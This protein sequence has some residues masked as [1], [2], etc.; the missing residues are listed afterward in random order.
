[1]PQ[2]YQWMFYELMW[3][4]KAH[5][6]YPLPWWVQQYFRHWSDSYDGGL[7]DSKQAAF[8]SNANYR[9]WNM[10]GVKDHHQESLVGQA[11]E[12]EP[13]NDKYTVSFFLFDP[14][15]RTVKFP[16]FPEANGS[17]SPL[18]QELEDGYL[19]VVNTTWRS[20]L[21]VTVEAKALATTVGNRQRSVVL[22]QYRAR[23]TGAAPARLWLCV[24]VSAH[25]VTGLDRRFQNGD[26]SD[27]RV[28]F[29]KYLPAEQRLE[30]NSTWGPT[31]DTP[32]T[33]FGLYG[34]DADSFDP[35]TYINNSPYQDLVANGKLNGREMVADRIAGLCTGVFAWE[36]PQSSDFIV[37]LRLPV[38]DFRGAD[39]LAEL[40]S[41]APD[42]LE[43]NNRNFW[44]NKLDNTGLQAQLPPTVEHLFKLFRTCR[45]NILILADDGAI[46]PG[47]TIYDSFWIRD[48][49]VEGVACALS[50]EQ[51]LP[52]QQFSR[53]YPKAFNT[54]RDR[55]GPVSLYGFFGDEHEKND[56]EWDSNG[57]AL[58]A[59][60]RFDRIL[61]QQK[62]F[63]AGMFSPYIIDGARWIR[64]NRSAF[65][66]L[67]SGWSAE[68]LGDKDKPHYWDD[69]W[70]IAG[71]YEA[72][73]LAERI[74]A[75]SA[76][77][78]WSIYDDVVR[79]TRDSMRWVLGEQHRQG[80]WET[81]IPTGP[82]DAG[83]LDSTLIGMVA[84]FHPCR[85]YM[86]AKLGADIDFAARATLD[87]I[88][89]HFIDG[90]F[91]HDSAWN[92]YGPYLTLQLAH[93]FLL[94]GDV[95]RMDHCL[96]WVVG[97]AGYAK[98][99][100]SEG[101]TDQWQVV[102]GA[103]NEQ[104]CYPIAKN[105]AEFPGRWWYMGDIPHG[106]ACA[107]FILLLR[108]MLFF[109]A[110]ED[111]QPQI[112]LAPGILPQWLNEGETVG[113]SDAPTIF[114]TPFGYK[115]I[116]NSGAKTV[117]IEITQAPPD[118]VRLIYHCRFGT[119]QTAIANT[120]SLPIAGNEIVLPAGTRQ[121]T[122]TYR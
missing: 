58:W 38:D 6:N 34:N 51:E 86:G 66:L 111:G 121:A 52:T 100:R 119:V 80:N 10:I 32:P 19:P 67:H 46:H 33:A 79:A 61:G 107:E 104:H 85:L 37:N 88:W 75:A 17:Q 72:A 13:V 2:T 25:G 65:G 7:F 28:S 31:F 82:A 89:A 92:C 110:D 76:G 78:I 44:I 103:W 18:Q 15:A 101:S 112:Y 108:D 94:I 116:H 96:N 22:A 77:E 109:E 117:Q 74:G 24:A 47:P 73:R 83:K 35:D 49:S 43:K 39:D 70:A 23:L 8:A 30:V 113:V 105:F 53:H 41:I 118:S 87:T 95:D 20:P 68:H 12:L 122:I 64:D 3:R 11:G 115:L 93:A 26:Q 21:G 36:I 69:M 27:R 63:G 98:V 1:M 91:R 97:N 59:I 54:S 9:Y 71:L 14:V 48:S 45:A 40:R 102:L 55:I 62:A 5:G 120:A 50:G 90:G 57:Q 60:S 4:A 114:G 99:S 42:V 16:Q 106:W 84:Y 81:Y 56:R 29:L